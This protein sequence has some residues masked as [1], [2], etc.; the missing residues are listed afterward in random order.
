MPG[1][2]QRTRV[3][4]SKRWV[5]TFNHYATKCPEWRDKLT[6]LIALCD[7]WAVQEEVGA[8]NGTP[9]L[10]MAFQFRRGVRP[11][12][13]RPFGTRSRM[14][15]TSN[16]DGEVAELGAGD[17]W[18]KMRAKGFEAFRYC[19]KEETRAPEGYRTWH[20]V[21]RP[22]RP[23]QVI[24]YRELR[25]WQKAIF[26]ECT[27]YAARD[28]RVINWV[29]EPNGRVGKS[30]LVKCMYDSDDFG[31]CVVGGRATDM[32]SSVSTY[33][34]NHEGAGPD[35][36]IVDIPRVNVGGISYQGIEGLKNGMFFNGKYESKDV[37]FNTPHIWVFANQPPQWQALSHDRWRVQEIVGE[38]ENAHLVPT[39]VQVPF[40][41]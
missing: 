22:P 17:W 31:V 3:S 23:L 8:V 5:C 36:I 32:L 11:N 27:E 37:R 29:W 2:A 38:G 25:V 20:G 19:M 30:F 18:S 24:E 16:E 7:V 15:I 6:A 33:I 9:H 28:D 14:A 35:V 10:Q 12:E 40:F 4:A 26:D 21:P 13:L 34:E 41:P 1:L 39:P